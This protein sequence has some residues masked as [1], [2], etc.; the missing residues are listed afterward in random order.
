M[1]QNIQETLF[2]LWKIWKTSILAN[3]V[4]WLTV[5]EI[6]LLILPVLVQTSITRHRAPWEQEIHLIQLHTV[7]RRVSWKERG[8]ERKE[9][10]GRKMRGDNTDKWGVIYNSENYH[11][12]NFLTAAT[13][14]AFRFLFVFR[15]SKQGLTSVC[16][17]FLLYCLQSFY[18]TTHSNH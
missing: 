7:P 5:T 13:L 11:L 14:I 16:S 4:S 10:E 9:E 15:F 17:N 3:E 1:Y 8:K 6:P 12:R 2:S 18:S